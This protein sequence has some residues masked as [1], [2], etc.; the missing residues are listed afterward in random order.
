MRYERFWHWRG[1]HFGVDNEHFSAGD[2][3]DENMC[4]NFSHTHTHAHTH[5]QR[6]GACAKTI[7][8]SGFVA[9]DSWLS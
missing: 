7:G 3:R 1:M 6:G 5:T 9:T 8:R 4:L 2:E